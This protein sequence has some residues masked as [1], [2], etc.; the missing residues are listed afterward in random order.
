MTFAILAVLRK[1]AMAGMLRKRLR[2]RELDSVGWIT[3]QI[4]YVHKEQRSHSIGGVDTERWISAEQR[5]VLGKNTSECANYP[6]V[7]RFD[8]Q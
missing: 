2:S 4:V 1:W 5:S 3:S 8:R 6:Q 7:D